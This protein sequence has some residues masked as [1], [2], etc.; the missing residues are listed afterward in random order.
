M[1]WEI[2]MDGEFKTN[3]EKRLCCIVSHRAST[4][5]SPYNTSSLV[6]GQ[7]RRGWGGALCCP[8]H[9]HRGLPLWRFSEFFHKF[10]P[11]HFL[12]G[13]RSLQGPKITSTWGQFKGRYDSIHSI[14]FFSIFT[15]ANVVDLDPSLETG[16]DLLQTQN[17]IKNPVFI[18]TLFFFNVSYNLLFI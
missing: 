10:D 9:Q 12:G 18:T 6:Q 13:A 16:L 14:N 11:V 7:R 4:S 15:S 17:R 8:H 1:N 2:Y 5:S 3:K